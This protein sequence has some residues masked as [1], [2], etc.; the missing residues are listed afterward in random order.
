VKKQ[1]SLILLSLFLSTAAPAK[2]SCASLYTADAKVQSIS[3]FGLLHAEAQEALPELF[4]LLVWNVK[5]GEIKGMVEDF[6]TLSQDANLVLLQEMVDR[7]DLTTSISLAQ[8]QLSWGMAQAFKW[9]RSENYTGVATGST[10][11]P[12]RENSFLSPVVEPIAKTPKS[13]LV[14][15]YKLGRTGLHTLVA[16]NLHAINFVTQRSFELHMDQVVQVIRSHKGPLVVAGDFNTWSYPRLEYME[17]VLQSLGL[18][19]LNVGEAGW[20]FPFDHIFVRG[21]RLE[22]SIDLTRIE[23]SDHKPLM[24]DLVY[25]PNVNLLKP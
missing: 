2:V 21:L 14:T 10:A 1:L 25:D 15:E 4:R 24:V 5:K 7:P 11:K 19:N 13:L 17:S 6:R 23:S 8:P 3:R 22:Q 16:L 20:T 18:E 12:L 9:Q